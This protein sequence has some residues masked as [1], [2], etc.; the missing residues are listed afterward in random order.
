[1]YLGVYRNDQMPSHTT[2][3]RI[4]ASTPT[5]PKGIQ[6]I[7]DAAQ[8]EGSALHEKLSRSVGSL[9]L[10]DIANFNLL[11]HRSGAALATGS[12]SHRRARGR[13]KQGRI[14]FDAKGT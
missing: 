1:M 8:R 4:L 6:G 7:V 10:G 2:T 11:P 13:P 12:A 9:D 5:L 14:V 3:L